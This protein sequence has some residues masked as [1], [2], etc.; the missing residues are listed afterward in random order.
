MAKQVAKIKLTERLAKNHLTALA[1]NQ[2]AL[3]ILGFGFLVP[4]IQ[5]E[6]ALFFRNDVVS[7]ESLEV[8]ADDIVES[9]CCVF[10][11]IISDILVVYLNEEQFDIIPTRKKVN[12]FL[13]HRT[14]ELVSFDFPELQPF[15]HFPFIPIQFS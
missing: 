6:I 13:L 10:A 1:R 15:E 11:E 5:L 3:T 9:S 7:E 4:F 2:L 8:Q 12:E 14:I